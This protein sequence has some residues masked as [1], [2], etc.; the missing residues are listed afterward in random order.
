M[1]AWTDGWKDGWSVTKYLEDEIINLCQSSSIAVLKLRNALGCVRMILNEFYSV[2]Y[3][4]LYHP[5]LFTTWGKYY[6]LGGTAR[7]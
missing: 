5:P 6:S 7:V 3:V 4:Y 2:I 1:N